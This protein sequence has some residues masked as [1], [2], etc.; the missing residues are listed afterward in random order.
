MVWM[1]T[2]VSRFPTW[3][4]DGLAKPKYDRKN[5]LGNFLCRND[6]LA[7]ANS[8]E[9]T[10]AVVVSDILCSVKACA[11]FWQVLSFV[12]YQSWSY[13]QE[14]D[15][16]V[17]VFFFKQHAGRRK[18]AQQCVH[19][20]SGSLRVFKPFFWLRV[21]SAPKPSPSPPTCG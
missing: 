9:A 5:N 20:T 15:V 11:R 7:W 8:L 17:D 19:P 4:V 13:A 14:F 16:R 21:F 2:G 3:M 10:T 12:H 6:N 1:D 18:V